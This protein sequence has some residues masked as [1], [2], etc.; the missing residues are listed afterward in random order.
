MNGAGNDFLIINNIKEKI[1]E[2]KVA[3][4]AKTLCER[5]LSIGAD[6]L[7]L[8]TGPTEEFAGRAD[9]RM[10]FYNSDGSLGEMCGNGARCISRYG[11]ETGLSGCRQKIETTAGLVTGKR[12]TEREYRVRLNDPS[13]IELEEKVAAEGKTYSMSYIELGYP[14]VPH[15]VC[16]LEKIK[17]ISDEEL[18]RLG[19]SLR[20]NNVFKK[21]A[22]INFYEVLGKDHIYIKTYE[23][24]V[25]GFTY[26]CGTG[27]GS[28]V[29][30]LTLKGVLS[31][32]NVRV[33]VKGGTLYIEIEREA[34]TVRGIFLTGPTNIVA[35]GVVTDEELL[36]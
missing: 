8:V 28:T 6:G 3:A 29:L 34:N 9:F 24:G 12:I 10:V 35:K 13:V 20:Y 2:D 31:G 19:R 14:G 17:N 22:N 25:E 32:K 26:A 4:I 33:D 1:P 5:H 36:L 23:R 27:A 18:I 11:Y 30:A 7:M 21:G 15:G 16:E